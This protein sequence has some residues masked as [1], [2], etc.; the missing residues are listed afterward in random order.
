MG[1]EV[2]RSVRTP[3]DREKERLNEE[4]LITM[5]FYRPSYLNELLCI[6]HL[7]KHLKKMYDIK[8]FS[9]LQH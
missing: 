4:L 5:E 3:T 1:I 8:P 6:P 9:K 7:R 2:F